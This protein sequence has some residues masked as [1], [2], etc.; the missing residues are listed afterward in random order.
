MSRPRFEFVLTEGLV[1]AAVALRLLAQA[2]ID[3]DGAAQVANGNPEF[4]ERV[5]AFNSIARESPVFALPDL[6]SQV[7]VGPVLQK[8]VPRR[9]PDLIIRLAVPMV[10]AWL[11]ADSDG[12][13]RL[14]GVPASKVPRSPDAEPH[15]KRLLVNLARQSS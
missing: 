9:Q 5:P 11:L 7:C 13:S 6:E 12:V 3:Y 1:D 8:R 2:G 10:E 15:P 4:W 14:L